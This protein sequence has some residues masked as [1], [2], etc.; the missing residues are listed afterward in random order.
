MA[1]K[2]NHEIFSFFTD[3]ADKQ[4]NHITKLAQAA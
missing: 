4:H 2:G 3:A 1:R